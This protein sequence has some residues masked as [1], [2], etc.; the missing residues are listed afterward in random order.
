MKSC[1]IFSCSIFDN[2]RLFV[3]HQFM[4][5]FKKHYS[6]CDI[7]IGINPGSVSNIV[8]VIDSYN[9]NTFIEFVPTHLYNY[10]DA[11]GYQVALYNLAKSGKT[12]TNIWFIHTK[13]GVNSHSD[14]LRDWYNDTFLSNRTSIEDFL[15]QYEMIGS[16]GML[17]LEF[18]FNRVYDETDAGFD[19]FKNTLTPELPYTHQHFFY[20]HSIYVIS[21]GP[22]DIFLNLAKQ[23]DWFNIKLD[24]Y[25]FEGV[26][27]FIVSR[28]GYF[29]YISNQ[30]TCNGEDLKQL[31]NDWII[32]N[33]LIHY[34]M[35]NSF[36]KTNYS[37]HQLTPPLC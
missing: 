29:P 7:Y 10:S 26:F 33:N 12:Y 23:T 28:S 18:D 34:S 5:T 25:Y 19:I 1:I 27:P 21:S 15:N 22:I 14:Y 30:L 2:T 17:G 37:F 3:L 35:Y 6:D 32:E 9:L 13:S 20:L 31:T 8:D 4:Q 11:S 16:Y 24:R 36:Y